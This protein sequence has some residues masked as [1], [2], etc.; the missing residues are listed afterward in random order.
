MRDDVNI[1]AYSTACIFSSRQ[2][3][4]IFREKYVFGGNVLALSGEGEYI[5]QWG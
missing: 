2:P 1:H 3:G 4:V 5:G